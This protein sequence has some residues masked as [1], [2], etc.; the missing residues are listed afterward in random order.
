MGS[1]YTGQTGGESLLGDFGCVLFLLEQGAMVIMV[2][3]TIDMLFY[4]TGADANKP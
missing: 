1:K 4:C 3:V 2:I